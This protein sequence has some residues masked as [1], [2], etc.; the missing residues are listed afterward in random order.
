MT[1][2]QPVPG[3]VPVLSS[4]TTTTTTTTSTSSLLNSVQK[5]FKKETL[6]RAL[7]SVKTPSRASKQPLPKEELEYLEALKLLK[8]SDKANHELKTKMQTLDQ[9]IHQKYNKYDIDQLSDM[10]QSF[11]TKVADSMERTDSHLFPLSPGE[12]SEVLDF[13][14]RCV[15]SRNSK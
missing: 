14:E 3:R 12:K 1:L 15:I 11:Y 2:S 13:F 6:K 4:P 10:V 9:N 8:L 7:T 5:T